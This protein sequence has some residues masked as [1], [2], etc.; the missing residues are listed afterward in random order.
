MTSLCFAPRLIPIL[1]YSYDILCVR[2]EFVSTFVS[3]FL[4]SHFEPSE[5]WSALAASIRLFNICYQPKPYASKYLTNSSAEA[6]DCLRYFT[7]QNGTFVHLVPCSLLHISRTLNLPLTCITVFSD[8]TSKRENN[9]VRFPLT[10]N[11]YTQSFRKNF[12]MI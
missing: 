8:C 6:Y 7:K 10:D 9:F 11:P 2:R 4:P 1:G 3:H 12:G 5:N